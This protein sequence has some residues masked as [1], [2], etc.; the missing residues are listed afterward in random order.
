[1]FGSKHYVTMSLT[2]AR[3]STLNLEH[4]IKIVVKT[5]IHGKE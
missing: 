5:K 4:I 3:V 1:M 2:I